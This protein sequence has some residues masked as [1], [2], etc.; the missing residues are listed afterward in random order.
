M[1]CKKCGST[2]E[3]T[4]KFCGYCGEK[5]NNENQTQI[6]VQNIE[7]PIVNNVVDNN[8]LNQTNLNQGVVELPVLHV[9]QQNIQ[10]PE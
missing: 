1:I 5:V 8:S 7:Q 9:V 10:V 3:D 6:P 4:S 2:I